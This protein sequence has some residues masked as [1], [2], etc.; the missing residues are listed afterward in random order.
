[1]SKKSQM[2]ERMVV[3]CLI[4]LVLTNPP[5]IGILSSVNGLPPGTLYLYTVG[6]IGLISVFAWRSADIMYRR[7][8]RRSDQPGDRP[9]RRDE[10][11]PS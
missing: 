4:A 7:Y 8:H 11:G 10:M 3:G 9:P 2:K 6:A 1:M 5:L